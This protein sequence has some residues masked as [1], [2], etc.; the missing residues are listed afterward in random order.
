MLA[1]VSAI[2]L[3]E[4][5]R[6][7][8][9]TVEAALPRRRTRRVT[10]PLTRLREAVDHF[11]KGM[12]TDIA[13][14]DEALADLAGIGPTP[15]ASVRAAIEAL[16]CYA[17]VIDGDASWL[18]PARAAVQAAKAPPP[19]KPT[20]DSL[21]ARIEALAPGDEAGVVELAGLVSEHRMREL[22]GLVFD[23]L[24]LDDSRGIPSG[25]L[26]EL[27]RAF[28]PKHLADFTALCAVRLASPSAATRRWAAR[29]LQTSSLAPDHVPLLAPLLHDADARVRTEAATALRMVA[30]WHPLAKD[31]VRAIA[32]AAAAKEPNDRAIATLVTAT[33]R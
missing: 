32:E 10:E 30:T 14:L 17:R 7:C 13:G 29:G 25:V 3:V 27:K 18:E 1:G 19:A 4:D 16:V 9:T 22:A 2:D 23:K 24:E 28:L 5:I 8:I 6:T 15:S 31:E 21:R 12:P 20:L 33:T 11:E 26:R